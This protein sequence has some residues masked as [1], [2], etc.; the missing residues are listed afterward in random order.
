MDSKTRTSHPHCPCALYN[1]VRGKLDHISI[2]VGVPILVAKKVNLHTLR[3]QS[4]DATKCAYHTL[5]LKLS[6]V[7]W[8][9]YLPKYPTLN[10]IGTRILL[11]PPP[12]CAP[13]L[14]PSKF[15]S[16]SPSEAV[17]Q[18]I[19]LQMGVECSDLLR[20]GLTHT[21]VSARWCPASRGRVMDTWEV[22]Y[23][24]KLTLQGSC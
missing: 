22:P 3:I 8:T 15:P 2:R 4:R 14:L 7:S 5:L 21:A 18:S 12:A 6:H 9:P 13:Y 23:R 19:V 11:G 16:Q 10:T 20:G 17:A 1:H 24:N